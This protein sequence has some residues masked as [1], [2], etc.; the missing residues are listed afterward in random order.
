MFQL[1]SVILIY[2]ESCTYTVNWEMEAVALPQGMR[3]YLRLRGR[4]CNVRGHSVSD[5]FK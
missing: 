5:S 2:I 4:T 1:V 3:E